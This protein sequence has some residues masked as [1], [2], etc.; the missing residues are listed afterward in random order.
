MFNKI[1]NPE[2]NRKV[3]IYSSKGKYVLNNYVGKDN[4]QKGGTNHTASHS[5]AVVKRD[6]DSGS[7]IPKEMFTFDP[8][9]PTWLSETPPEKDLYDP[10]IPI[11][12]LSDTELEE[13]DKK[14]DINLTTN[15]IRLHPDLRIKSNPEQ[16]R[17]WERES[18]AADELSKRNLEK[19]KIEEQRAQR[20]FEASERHKRLVL[21]KSINYISNHAAR[22]EVLLRLELPTDVLDHS[23]QLV[24]RDASIPI[25]GKK[26]YPV[27]TLKN[28]REEL[29]KLG[30]NIDHLRTKAPMKELIKKWM[31]GEIT[32]ESHNNN[33]KIA[34]LEDVNKEY[35]V[36]ELNNKY[37]I[38]AEKLDRET[39][40]QVLVD[41]IRGNYT[42]E[43]IAEDKAAIETN[44]A[45]HKE[46]DESS[47][48]SYLLGAS[49]SATDVYNNCAKI[50]LE[51]QRKNRK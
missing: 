49:E 26:S 40:K 5:D 43:M 29:K 25:T 15:K 46:T 44:C 34:H 38:P 4:L 9:K 47:L 13:L 42:D 37:G 14:N 20:N 16:L 12:S 48:W 6:G 28:I 35:L 50:Q 39:A 51:R 36:D 31:L 10:K 30:M 21:D 45:H 1:V 27:A 18:D 2:T 24:V 22:D 17:R 8:P 11:Q 19:R 7:S 3:S 33:V 41:I 23:R 32:V